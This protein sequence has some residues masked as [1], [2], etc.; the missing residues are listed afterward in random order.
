MSETQ[1]VIALSAEWVQIGDAAQQVLITPGNPGHSFLIRYAAAQP[2]SGVMSGHKYFAK[3][4]IP[5]A[6]LGSANTDRIWIRLIGAGTENIE[7]TVL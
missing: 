3:D 7:V 1:T 5:N 4:D 6:I 2:A